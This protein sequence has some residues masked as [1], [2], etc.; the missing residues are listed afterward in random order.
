[1]RKVLLATISAL[2]CTTAYAETYQATNWMAPTHILNGVAYER[3][4]AD[5]KEATGG[6]VDFELF[7]SG[8][9]VPAQTTLSAVGDAVAQL[10]V[11]ASSYTPSELPLSGM[12]NDLAFVA[13][14]DMATALAVTEISMNNQR[15]IDEFAKYNT[16]TL[17]AYS[18]P[19]YVFLCMSELGDVASL[20]GKKIRTNGTAQNEWIASLGAIPVAV[21]MTDVYSGLERG[22]IDC[23]LS[24]PTNLIAGYKFVE[25][26][27]T[28]T[29]L[30]QGTALGLTYVYNK[31]FWEDIGPENRRALL[32]ATARNVA[33]TQIAYAQFVDLALNESTAR[34][35]AINEPD[36]SLVD[37]LAT[38][39]T[40][41]IARTPERTAKERRVADPSAVANEFLALQEKW[42][43][44]LAT[45]DRYDEDALTALVRSEIYSK[46]DENSYGL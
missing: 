31:D 11:V 24:D 21:P 12:I 16:L 37:A 9:L 19:T 38:F 25:V 13:E 7:S 17:G 22:S 39:R 2:V 29:M 33:R 8:S 18:T 43:T 20:R 32:D 35:I 45:I 6:K 42:N 26:A 41:L 28:I 23:T 14:D 27:K 5:A 30:Q 4:I 46:I 40:D 3:F 44:L 15:L 36:P 10:G 34:G 1:M